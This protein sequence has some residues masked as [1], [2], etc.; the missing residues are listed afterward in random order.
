MLKC[1]DCR[2]YLLNAEHPE[3][4]QC[5]VIGYGDEVTPSDMVGCDAG[6]GFSR[7]QNDGG[8][9]YISFYPKPEFGCVLA[10]EIEVE[11]IDYKQLLAEKGFIITVSQ[12]GK[13]KYFKIVHKND[14]QNV[15]TMYTHD[16]IDKVD[17]EDVIKRNEQWLKL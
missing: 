15:N 1:K 5:A 4:N 11:E 8:A 17:Y 9:D 3:F 12:E 6:T 14:L 16:R 2:H 13:T 7:Q 10:E